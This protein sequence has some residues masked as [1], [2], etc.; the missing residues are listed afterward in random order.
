MALTSVNSSGVKGKLDRSLSSSSIDQNGARNKLD[1]TGGG[2]GSSP[3]RAAAATVSLVRTIDRTGD[4]ELR[5]RASRSGGG[6]GGEKS[7]GRAKSGDSHSAAV[8]GGRRERS[9]S[10]SQLAVSQAREPEQNNRRPLRDTRKSLVDRQAESLGWA[11]KPV[12]DTAPA[13]VVR[14]RQILPLRNGSSDRRRA[15]SPSARHSSLPDVLMPSSTTS[16]L[17]FG[18]CDDSRYWDYAFRFTLKGDMGHHCREC[19][20]PF[21]VL[22][23]AIAVRRSGNCRCRYSHSCRFHASLVKQNIEYC[24]RSVILFG[25]QRVKRLAR[26]AAVQQCT[27]HQFVVYRVYRMQSPTANDTTPWVTVSI[28]DM[29]DIKVMFVARGHLICR[30]NT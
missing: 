13:A 14:P 23:E 26:C 30:P 4:A 8:P 18:S 10:S 28:G 9:A 1:V 7:N 3:D 12:G 2:R 27:E 29:I 24:T 20:R 19:K 17:F 6:R 22:N 16:A 11:A 15:S 21:S 5:S 25:Y